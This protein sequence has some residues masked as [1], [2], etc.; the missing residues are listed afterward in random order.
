MRA[1]KHNPKFA[2]KVGVS[3]S[4]G[5]EF[6]AADKKTGRYA[7]GGLAQVLG[8]GSPQAL[9]S[10]VPDR[11]MGLQETPAMLGRADRAITGAAQQLGRMRS[12]MMMRAK[13]GK[14]SKMEA[15]I[16]A[17]K[18]AIF[19]ESDEADWES[20]HGFLKQI[21]GHEKSAAKLDEY[22][23]FLYKDGDF[24]ESENL[25]HATEL[26]DHIDEL[27]KAHGVKRVPNPNE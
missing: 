25:R 22:K 16:K 12:N 15:L 20:A 18:D 17:A 24:D 5:A 3:Q 6:V 4:V 21:P 7:V 14:V 27:G 26:E 10:P 8:R 23:K 2:K 13:G 11:R 9:A 1:V 19:G